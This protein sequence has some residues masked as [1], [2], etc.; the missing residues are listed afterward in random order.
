MKRTLLLLLLLP[1]AVS[2]QM[3]NN[4]SSHWYAK[5]TNLV[6][7]PGAVLVGT[8]A[9]QI[10]ALTTGDV[11]KVATMLPN[12]QAGWS[13]PPAGAASIIWTNGSGGIGGLVTISGTATSSVVSNSFLTLCSKVLLTQ[14]DTPLNFVDHQVVRSNGFF[15]VY[16]AAAPGA[17]N[18]FYVEWWVADFCNTNIVV[19]GIGTPPPQSCSYVF[20]P[21]ASSYGT[22][23]GAGS[24]TL[25]TEGGCLYS[26]T[27]DVAWVTLTSG[28]TNSGS[29]TVAF[30]VATN[31]GGTAR[32]GL[33]A[34]GATKYTVSQD[35]TDLVMWFKADDSTLAAAYTNNQP[36]IAWTNAV[37][38]TQYLVNGS[39]LAVYRT[40]QLNG[41]PT[42]EF[43]GGNNDNLNGALTY[44]EWRPTNVTVLVVIR[45]DAPLNGFD[46]TE[47]LFANSLN[48]AFGWQAAMNYTSSTNVQWRVGNGT[49]LSSTL[50]TV[51]TNTWY[52][53]AGTYDGTTTR[54]Y[55]NGTQTEADATVTGNISY[56]ATPFSL[57]F[58][59]AEGQSNRHPAGGLAE[60]KGY[61][62][63]MSS[64]EVVTAT[65]ALKGKWGLP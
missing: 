54:L 9:V 22:N 3:V 38:N 59:T 2:A 28:A 33:V 31:T 7:K 51:S 20:S 5:G 48:T 21:T 29:G 17:G 45:V 64:N 52:V 41:L 16:T 36:L 11:G 63:A 50:A 65:T 37:V 44:S 10:N 1:L 43:T 47:W 55:L 35:G 27:T 13:N 24:F 4:L 19:G 39:S 56:P 53:V 6:A 23:G 15:T 42:F 62:R 49:S 58:M 18:S 40:N 12:G 57:L 46:S 34:L 60:F 32:S 25:T 8:N 14:A 61:N 30:N 26:V